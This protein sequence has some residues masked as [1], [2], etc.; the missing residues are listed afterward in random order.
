MTQVNL[1]QAFRSFYVRAVGKTQ[2]SPQA[3]TSA[4]VHFCADVR[5]GCARLS[6]RSREPAAV[7]TF[8]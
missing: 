3:P 1:L 4:K 7:S 5:A 6:G 2:V 8:A